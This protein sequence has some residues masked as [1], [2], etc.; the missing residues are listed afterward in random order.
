MEQNREL[1]QIIGQLY[2]D[3]YR[4][5]FVMQQRQNQLQEKEKETGQ[6]KIQVQTLEKELDKSKTTYTEFRNIVEKQNESSKP[7]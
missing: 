1:L 2:T 7:K 6:Y 4:A 5:Q 3:L